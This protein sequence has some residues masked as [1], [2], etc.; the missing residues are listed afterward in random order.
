MKQELENKKL[1]AD[2][3]YT[4]L[5]RKV[6]FYS[7][8]RLGSCILAVCMG[9]VFFQERFLWSLLLLIVSGIIFIV[10]VLIHSNLSKE[11]R[12]SYLRS[13][14]YQDILARYSEDWKDLKETGSNYTSNVDLFA[15]D[16]DIVGKA[17]LYQY[18]CFA[19]TVQGKEELAKILLH[20]K[21]VNKEKIEN[22]QTVVKE[23][24]N[25]KDFMLDFMIRGYMFQYDS[26]VDEDRVN[27]LLFRFANNKVLF[28]KWEKMLF[29][30]LLFVLPI[31]MILSLADIFPKVSLMIAVIVSML[32]YLR[33]FK[34]S[35]ESFAVVNP[36][37]KSII[38]YQRMIEVIVNH[39]F[40]GKEL[41]EIKNELKKAMKAL[42]ELDSVI[43]LFYLR[44]NPIFYAALNLFFLYDY[45]CIDKLKKWQE[46]Y[47]QSLLSWIT[48]VGKMEA[49][50]SLSTPIFTKEQI[51][52]PTIIEE[53]AVSLKMKNGIHPLMNEETAIANNIAL[54]GE[55]YVITGSNMAGKTTFL[56]TLGVN[57]VLMHAGSVVCCEEFVACPMEIL[58]S[59]RVRDDVS[60]GV[61]TFYGE[62]QRIKKMIEFLKTYKKG[63]L[64]IDEIFKGTNLKDRIIGAQKTMQKLSNQNLI[65]M[66]TTHDEQLTSHKEVDVMNYHFEEYYQNDQIF[67]DYKIKKGISTSTN[68]E[69]LMKMVGILD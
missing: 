32:M 14:A 55:C 15:F 42:H 59:M 7:I 11:S 13:E 38:S 43:G 31:I 68:A 37:S 48:L 27:G 17:S 65:T 3:L 4:S 30:I 47:D 25:S 20:H 46:K 23:L 2:L 28:E 57:L 44:Q 67:F 33:I 51:T 35:S 34:R 45:L 26:D 36:L 66:I 56:R 62:L 10:S 53:D 61:S 69:F 5:E 54:K 63:I 24:M 52:F 60:T 64:L 22:R 1:E 50:I 58:T 8:I 6:F 39:D 12:I 9:V 18:L 19:K 41:N 40:E 29:S 49:F 16:L 21:N